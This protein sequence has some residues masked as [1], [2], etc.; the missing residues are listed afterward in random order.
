VPR[1]E[2]YSPS[3]CRVNI[4]DSGNAEGVASAMYVLLRS[5]VCKTMGRMG[6]HSVG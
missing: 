5:V 4:W 6:C 2:V 1:F 3:R